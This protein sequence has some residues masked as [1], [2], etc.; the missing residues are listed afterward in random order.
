MSEDDPLGFSLVVVEQLPSLDL[1]N[2]IKLTTSTLSPS[3]RES[4][5]RRSG[6]S[7]SPTG[8]TRDDLPMVGGSYGLCTTV[9]TDSPVTDDDKR[10]MVDDPVVDSD[11]VKLS[12]DASGA[13]DGDGRRC[14]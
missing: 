5:L 7:S 14:F 4:A 3:M 11:G 13:S 9:E 1:L 10:L 6:S 8:V 12:V 2:R